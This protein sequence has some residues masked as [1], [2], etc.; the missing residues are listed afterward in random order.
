MCIQLYSHPLTHTTT[1]L[2]CQWKVVLAGCISTFR[3]KLLFL[4]SHPA[5]VIDNL[6]HCGGIQ[7]NL[8]DSTSLRSRSTLTLRLS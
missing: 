6:K 5:R 8:I 3:Q 7:T 2:P 4:V 1:T